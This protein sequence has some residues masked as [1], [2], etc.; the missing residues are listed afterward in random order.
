M[1][2]VAPFFV[3][4][5]SPLHTCYYSLLHACCCFLLRANCF[6]SSHLL[7]LP[8]LCLLLLRASCFSSSHLL[9]LPSLHLFLHASCF[10]SSHL[11]HSLLCPFFVLAAS[12]LC[13]CLVLAGNDPRLNCSPPSSLIELIKVDAT[14]EEEFEQ[15]KDEFEQDMDILAWISYP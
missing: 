3:L 15:Y 1:L 9:L 12:R 13:M 5:T 7:L 14:L 6:S 4:T 8:S 2:V 10:S 11:L